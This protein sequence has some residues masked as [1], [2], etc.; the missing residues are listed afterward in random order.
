MRAH[1]LLLCELRGQAMI[2]WQFAFDELTAAERQQ[3]VPLAADWGWYD[4]AVTAATSL[5]I[6]Y[7]YGLLYPQPYETSVIAAAHAAQLPVSLVYSVIRQE[8][9]YRTDVVSSAGARGLMQLELSTAKPIARGLKLPPPHMTDLFDPQINSTLGAEHLHLLLDKVN[10]QL[11]LALAAYNA[12]IAAASRWLPAG[13]IAPDVWV[14]NIPYNETRTYVQR[15]LWHTVV[16]AWL[17]SDGQA[18]DTASWLAPIRATGPAQ[19]RIEP[20]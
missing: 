10:G 1:E 4:L 18:Q 16:Y 15:I 20:P 12:G 8:S 11:P 14:E 13:S 7:D 6:F 17:R 3:A 5:H 9:L 19:A 2:E